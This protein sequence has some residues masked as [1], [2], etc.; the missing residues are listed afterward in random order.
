MA[1]NKKL[2]QMQAVISAKKKKEPDLGDESDGDKVQFTWTGQPSKVSG[3]GE[4][5]TCQRVQ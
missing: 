3:R 1:D 4:T 2:P 5:E